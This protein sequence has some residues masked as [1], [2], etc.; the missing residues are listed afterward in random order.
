[1]PHENGPPKHVV[2]VGGGFAGL[3]CARSLADHDEVRVTLIDRNNYHQFQPLFYQVATSVLPTEDVAFPLREVFRKD[4]DVDIKIGEVTAVDPRT[5]TVTTA[6]GETYQGDF[7]VL[8]AGSQPNFFKTPGA[9][10]AFPLY[11]LED[12]ES[13]RT[14]IISAFEEA[15]RDDS[16]IEDGALNFVIVGGGA[17]GTEIAGAIA[18]MIH[19]SVAA[20]YPD[21]ALSASRVYIYDHGDVLLAP[22]SEGG[23]EYAAKILQ[24]NGVRLRLGH[25]IKEV[26]AGH[27]VDSDGT[28]IRTRCVIWAGGIKAAPLAANSGLPQG[29][30]GRIDVLPDLTLEEFPGVYVIGD[31][32]NI[33]SPDGA[34]FPQLGSVALQNGHYTAKAIL[35]DIEG[36]PRGSFHYTDKGMMAM[37][38][39]GHAIAQGGWHHH[40]LHGPIAFAA[41]LGVHVTLMTGVHSRVNAFTQWATEYFSSNRPLAVLDRSNAAQIDWT[42]DPAAGQAKSGD[43]N[44]ASAEPV[45]AGASRGAT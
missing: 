16:L 32:A 37:I 20:A 41:W 33:P 45:S 12:A 29:R 26:G 39:R 6:T 42:Q 24:K 27:V 23:H 2:V 31:F 21:L 10:H 25:S 38:D 40:E 4:H 35:K 7:L 9:E 8:A 14:R 34:F 11:S 15:D 36:K 5:R 18:D 17:T 19:S 43:D 1:M 22:F 13:L 44:G 3:G 30:G 28:T